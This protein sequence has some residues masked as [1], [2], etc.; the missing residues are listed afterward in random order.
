VPSLISG[1]AAAKMLEGVFRALSAWREGA[2]SDPS[3]PTRLRRPSSPTV[4]QHME[5]A[6][7]TPGPP[8]HNLFQETNT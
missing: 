8:P 3:I 7:G 6:G 2:R 5:G 1:C 4:A